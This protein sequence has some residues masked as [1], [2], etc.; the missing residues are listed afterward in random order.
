[1][2]PH[3]VYIFS[4][5]L[6]SCFTRSISLPFFILGIFNIVIFWPY[7]TY[8][9][10]HYYDTHLKYSQDKQHNLLT[11]MDTFH[12]KIDH[13]L[14]DQ[15]NGSIKKSD[16][17]HFHLE[18]Q[19]E[20]AC[21]YII[22]SFVG[23]TLSHGIRYPP[24]LDQLYICNDFF[25]SFKVIGGIIIYHFA[26]TPLI[27]I[28][29][30]SGSII[31][32]LF[33]L[34][35]TFLFYTILTSD[36]IRWQSAKSIRAFL[37]YTFTLI[38][39]TLISYCILLLFFENSNKLILS[40]FVAIIDL[41]FLLFLKCNLIRNRNR[42]ITNYMKLYATDK[43]HQ[44]YQRDFLC[45]STKSTI[46]PIAPHTTPLQDPHTPRSNSCS[47][48]SVFSSCFYRCRKNDQG[49]PEQSED[50]S[51]RKSIGKYRKHCT[52]DTLIDIQYVQELEKKFEREKLKKIKYKDILKRKARQKNHTQNIHNTSI[53]HISTPRSSESSNGLFESNKT[54]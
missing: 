49:T 13:V 23:Y 33:L 26:L 10:H 18:F 3:S 42:K 44:L 41:L 45:F 25:Y 14:L 2:V 24:M 5:I 27:F 40:S 32:G 46:T 19:F 54:S 47:I 28:G 50:S 11:S 7:I 21:I 43:H 38:I 9:Q 52:T 34:I 53:T 30:V 29:E 48:F 39:I 20:V 15:P 6:W 22:F 31:C 35:W 36:S 37:F 1:M 17:D 8:H 51:E 16:F 4:A 12:E